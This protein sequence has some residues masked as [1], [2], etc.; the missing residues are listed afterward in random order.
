VTEVNQNK[1]SNVPVLVRLTIG[2]LVFGSIWGLSEVALG[3]GLQ[4]ANFPYRAGL[5]TG[6]GI[7]I[8]GTALVIYKKPAML[9]GIGLV[10]V[11]VKLLAVPILHIAVMCKANSCIAVFTEA[12]ALSL[13]AF[14]LMSKMGKSV[15]VQIGAGASAA[16]VASAG[17]Y[18]VGMQVAPCQYLLSFTPGGFI[19]TEGLIWAAFSAILLPLGYLAGEKLAAINSPVLTRRPIYYAASASTVLFCWGVSALAIA[20]GL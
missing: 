14:L 19:V 4:A 17:F 18:F 9:I 13:V 16:I 3:G 7:A 6:I 5:L 1:L 20:A 11:L 12:V 8:M 2:I 10:T 15:H